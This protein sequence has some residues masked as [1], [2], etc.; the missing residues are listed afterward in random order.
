MTQETLQ[1]AAQQYLQSSEERHQYGDETSFID[2]AKWQQERMYSEEEVF[3]LLM[4]LS[5]VD[6]NSSSG[7]PHSIAKWFEQFKK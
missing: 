3:N 5:S 4:E 6:K 1:Q 2:G 7:T